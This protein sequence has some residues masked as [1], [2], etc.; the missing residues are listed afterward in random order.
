MAALLLDNEAEAGTYQ[1]A[2][3]KINF[4]AYLQAVGEFGIICHPTGYKRQKRDF[5]P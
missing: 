3:G 5:L 4:T 1:R 2:E